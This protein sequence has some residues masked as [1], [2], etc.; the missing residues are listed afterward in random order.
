MRF[1]LQVGARPGAVLVREAAPQ[2][3][4]MVFGF[5]GRLGSAQGSVSSF[6]ESHQV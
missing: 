3:M 1:P 5:K 4:P 6:P 2:V